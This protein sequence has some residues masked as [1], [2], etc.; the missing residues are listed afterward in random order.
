M[1]VS[2]SLSGLEIRRVSLATPR[3]IALVSKG[4][5]AFRSKD[6]ALACNEPGIRHK[7]TRPYRPQTNGKAERFI[8]SAL[9]KWAY[10][11]TY[12]TSSERTAA[13][14]YWNHHYNWH[15]P[16]QG[17]AGTTPK[18]R[19]NLHRNNLLTLHNYPRGLSAAQTPGP[20]VQSGLSHIAWA[21]PPHSFG[22]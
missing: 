12:Q 13:L 6:F 10:G 16:H 20:G 5:L 19:L 21:G 7:F 15:H 14:D 11:F 4:S 2:A 22:A 17:I 3:S 9:R 8:Q 18:S 1:S